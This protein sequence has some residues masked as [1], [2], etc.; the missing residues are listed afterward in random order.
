[1]GGSGAF[2]RPVSPRQ[3]TCVYG[4]P[5]EW[6]PGETPVDD[7]WPILALEVKGKAIRLYD[8]EKGAFPRR[9]AGAAVRLGWTD[10][11]FNTRDNF[12]YIESR[13]RRR[14]VPDRQVPR[15]VGVGR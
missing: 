2:L 12:E 11:L 8:E 10:P 15:Q 6:T 3:M 13:P 5:M 9:E 1:M 14:C 4:E 7:D